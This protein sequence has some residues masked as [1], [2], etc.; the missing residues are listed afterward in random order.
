[1]SAQVFSVNGVI[2]AIYH[3]EPELKRPAELPPEGVVTF[4]L[5]IICL[6]RF[7]FKLYYDRIY[8]CRTV[9]ASVPGSAVALQEDI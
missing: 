6:I 5:R 8:I 1:M 4:Y 3:L 9:V 2:F 7:A